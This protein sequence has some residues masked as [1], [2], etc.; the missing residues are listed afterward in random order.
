MS[1]HDDKPPVIYFIHLCCKSGYVEV[2]YSRDITD[3]YPCPDCGITTV[4]TDDP[5]GWW[6]SEED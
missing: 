4:V 2:D 1:K 6:P 5:N 3:P